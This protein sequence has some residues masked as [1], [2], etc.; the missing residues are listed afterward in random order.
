MDATVRGDPVEGLTVEF[1]RAIA[2]RARAYAWKAVTDTAGKASLT[3][4]G[5]RRSHV[6]GFY[7]ARAR[8]ADGDVV[9]QWHSIPLNRGMRQVLELTLGGDAR[10]VSSERLDAAKQ[11][12]EPGQPLAVGLE[13]NAPNPFNSST[14]IPYRLQSPGPVRLV[15]YNALGQPL[16]TLVEESQPA[17]AYLVH[18]DAR[19]RQGSAVAAGVYFARL[20]YPGGVQTRRMLYL[21]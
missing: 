14:R 1:S 19:D 17:G 6:G 8:T 7:E 5:S 18:W 12:A 15:I 4:S 2:G 3:I 20:H 9:G 10:V 13:P 16:R 21:K 11:A